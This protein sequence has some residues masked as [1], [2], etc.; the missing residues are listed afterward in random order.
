VVRTELEVRYLALR[1]VFVAVFLAYLIWNLAWLVQGRLAPSM[2]WALT[3]VPSPTTGGTRSLTALLGGD[4]TDSLQWN[5]CLIP[6]CGLLLI[7][8]IQL[9]RQ[10]MH[11]SPLRLSPTIAWCWF[12][13][14]SAAWILKL[15]VPEP[16]P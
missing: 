3:G 7:T 8:L 13:V 15:L 11:R 16:S 10:A 5:A 2:L 14:L 6:I 9:I 12:V 1:I 4:V